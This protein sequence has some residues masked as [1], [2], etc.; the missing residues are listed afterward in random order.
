VG[1]GAIHGAGVLFFLGIVVISQH[2]QRPFYYLTNEDSVII[3]DIEPAGFGWRIMEVALFNWIGLPLF[4]EHW[5][6]YVV[7]SS[8][9]SL[10]VAF[11]VYLLWLE[12]AHQLKDRNG[13]AL[14]GHAP[15]VL[16]SFLTALAGF[17]HSADLTGVSYRAAA[18]FCLLTLVFVFR[19][20]RTGNLRWWPC[21]M[22]SYLG[23]CL[24]HSFGWPL[25]ILVLLLEGALRRHDLAPGAGRRTVAR[26]VLLLCVPLAVVLITAPMQLQQLL[27]DG[28]LAPVNPGAE[29]RVLML[30]RMFYVVAVTTLVHTLSAIIP[31]LPGSMEW[32]AEVV[33]LAA[34]GLGVVRLQRRNGLDI[35]DL[36]VIFVAGW[37]LLAI[38][39]LLIGNL[40]W[41]SGSHRFNFLLPGPII[42]LSYLPVALLNRGGR[43]AFRF[44]SPRWAGA[45]VWAAVLIVFSESQPMYSIE[46][47]VEDGDLGLQ[48]PCP[49]L[50]ACGV[51]SEPTVAQLH[52]RKP[53]PQLKCADLTMKVLRGHSLQ[54]ADL[55]RANL[56]GAHLH[57][58][59]LTRA[60]L[61][62]SCVYYVDLREASLEGGDLRGAQ[63]IGAFL[64]R[65]NLSRADL[66]G[67]S[68]RST[69]V[70]EAN[71]KGANLSDTD[72]VQASFHGADLRGANL[73]RA[74][75]SFSN[76]EDADL[77][78]A[79]LRGA[80][81]LNA[82]VYG[83]RIEGANLAGAT[84]C[85]Q[86]AVWLSEAG[87]IKGAPSVVSCRSMPSEDFLFQP[88]WER[89]DP[90]A[91][92]K[93]C[94]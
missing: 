59:K 50:E 57:R 9:V 47:A 80:V 62:H 83:A 55:S 3:T 60:R 15:G 54:G 31:P 7:L 38:P 22:L 81:L 30:C 27:M 35:F 48:N 72:L 91:E 4:R 49:A 94:R 84:I 24:S 82:N 79:D 52:A 65:A 71:L 18:L 45:A 66:R 78:G 33:L 46:R 12:L 88:C 5:Q 69:H 32:V 93:N 64:N 21:A 29:I 34:I 90:S 89:E 41:S 63:I 43:L 53:A 75:L 2:F 36:L 61:P 77:R 13:A 14:G 73:T 58:A 39:S 11:L 67:A 86:N 85:Q 16:A 70:G 17:N 74:N 44:W 26:T 25:W 76:L 56:S 10:G 28:T 40:I 42:V 92:Q 8:L 6:G 51:M 87:S 1:W 20:H 37:F 68:L 23:A 19:Y